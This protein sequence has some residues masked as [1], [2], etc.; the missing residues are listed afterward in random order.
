MYLRGLIIGESRVESRPE[1]EARWIRDWRS[2][3]GVPWSRLIAL[4][5]HWF[6]ILHVRIELML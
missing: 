5:S 3:R 2:R 1:V 4:F 6:K